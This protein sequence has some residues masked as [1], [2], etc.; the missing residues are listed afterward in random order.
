VPILPC[1]SSLLAAARILSRR[2]QGPS[3]NDSNTLSGGATACIIF[4]SIVGI[5]LLGWIFRL[6]NQPRLPL[7]PYYY[8]KVTQ[9][10]LFTIAEEQERFSTGAVSG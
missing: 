5:L 3:D 10:A 4:G 9:V 7:R 6:A 2:Q 8:M 1:S